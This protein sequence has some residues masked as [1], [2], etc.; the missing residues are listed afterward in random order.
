MDVEHS[1]RLLAG[2]LHTAQQRGEASVARARLVACLAFMAMHLPLRWHLLLV[3]DLKSCLIIGGLTVGIWFSWLGLRWSAA[4]TVTRLRL[5]VSVAIDALVVFEPADAAT[6]AGTRGSFHGRLTPC[7]PWLGPPDGASPACNR[8][9]VEPAGTQVEV[10]AGHYW[11]FASAGPDATIARGEVR[12]DPG[13]LTAVD[14][15]LRALAVTPPGWLA[16]D[17]PADL[18]D[19]LREPGPALRRIARHPR[20]FGVEDRRADADA[21]DR[22]EDQRVTWRKSQ[23]GDYASDE[24]GLPQSAGR[25]HQVLSNG[26]RAN[27]AGRDAGNHGFYGSR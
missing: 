13:E 12:L 6:R 19:A 3:G 11:V 16:A 10:P 23:C 4:G 20:R 17:L 21:G 18:E 8:V 1:E 27:S 26:C 14:L 9:L 25:N 2:F 24:S 7:A 22:G 15:D 5:D